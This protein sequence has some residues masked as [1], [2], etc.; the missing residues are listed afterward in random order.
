MIGG[1]DPIEIY[2]NLR[3]YTKTYGVCPEVICREENSMI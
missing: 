3:D 1:N 2:G